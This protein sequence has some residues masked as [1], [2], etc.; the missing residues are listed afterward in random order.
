MYVIS[1]IPVPLEPEREF[2]DVTFAEWG[3]AIP[4]RKAGWEKDRTKWAW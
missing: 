1:S 4:P 3:L 2:T